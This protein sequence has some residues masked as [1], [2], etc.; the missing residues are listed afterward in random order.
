MRAII[1]NLCDAPG[2]PR[3]S[4]WAARL[5]LIIQ[6]IG[7]TRAEVYERSHEVAVVL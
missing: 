4:L 1:V 6:R 5:N 3:L 2:E 7:I